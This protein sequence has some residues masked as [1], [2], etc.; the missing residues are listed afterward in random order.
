MLL[1]GTP[2]APS[3]NRAI[4]TVVALL[5]NILI[6]AGAIANECERGDSKIVCPIK[7]TNQ[8]EVAGLVTN[9][10]IQGKVTIDTSN[11]YFYHVLFDYFND[12]KLPIH[13]YATVNL[14]DVASNFPAFISKSLESYDECGDRIYTYD[15][16]L[17]VNN[18]QLIAKTR[19]RYE[20]WL[21]TSMH[22]PEIHDWKPK[23]VLRRT[24]KNKLIQQSAT[25]EFGLRIRVENGNNLALEESF[26]NANLDGLGQIAAPLLGLNPNK[27]L[28]EELERALNGLDL[29][30]SLPGTM[31]TELRLL[32]PKM[33][34]QG[35]NITIELEGDFPDLTLSDAYEICK[36]LGITGERCG[37]KVWPI[38]W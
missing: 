9:I 28:R 36:N 6:S 11:I 3:G 35:E 34:Q 2:L 17:S 7:Q 10:G 25:L 20:N 1:I 19:V 5:A 38:F 4:V 8:T 18:D 37:L 30:S 26:H 16:S 14:S 12:K 27:L 22:V 13:F 23:M 29:L 32:D 33:R 15:Q 31:R 24:S 21:C